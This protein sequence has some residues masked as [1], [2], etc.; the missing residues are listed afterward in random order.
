MKYEYGI[1]DIKE[2]EQLIYIGTIRD[3]AK[4]LN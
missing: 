3:C 2:Y 4:F 1:Y